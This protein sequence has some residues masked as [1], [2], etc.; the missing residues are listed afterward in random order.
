MLPCKKSINSAHAASYLKMAESQARSI[1][2]TSGSK[3]RVIDSCLIEGRKSGNLLSARVIDPEH[4]IYST[5]LHNA[6]EL[7]SGIF[8]FDDRRVFSPFNKDI[9]LSISSEKN[10]SLASY[11]FGPTASDLKASSKMIYSAAGELGYY[12]VDLF[13]DTKNDSYIRIAQV[14]SNPDLNKIIFIHSSSVSEI[15][16]GY[17][18]DFDIS[19]KT[20]SGVAAELN[21]STLIVVVNIIKKYDGKP[22]SRDAMLMLAVTTNKDDGKVFIS[23][24]PFDYVTLPANLHPKIITYY[25]TDA[26]GKSERPASTRFKPMDIEITDD[27]RVLVAFKYELEYALDVDFAPVECHGLASWGFNAAYSEIHST[28]ID[29]HIGGP[30]A[31]AELGVNPEYA[32]YGDGVILVDGQVYRSVKTIERGSA[33]GSTTIVAPFFIELKNGQPIPSMVD[34]VTCPLFFQETQFP[35]GRL[36]NYLKPNIHGIKARVSSTTFV[37]PRG[38]KPDYNDAIGPK[39]I[40]VLFTDGSRHRF[41]SITD[42]PTEHIDVFA[43][44]S[45]PQVEIRKKSGELS[46]VSVIV[47][48]CVIN[49]ISVVAIRKGPIWPEDELPEDYMSLWT[50]NKTTL[51]S[52]NANYYIGNPLNSRPTDQMFALK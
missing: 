34:S 6:R 7:N 35:F 48:T 20:F 4:S 31:N 30:G 12:T 45:C 8:K 47:V 28:E 14:Y 38:E 10:L 40:G 33:S 16:H 37:T 23:G 39:S 27:K 32:M 11:F 51:K 42:M 2:S 24:D 22:S 9:L 18:V 36:E 50:F 46:S 44:T 21:E 49:G 26:G 3:V 13:K 52:N 41:E 25:N 43:H 29:D 1:K 17:T 5:P 15:V 19:K